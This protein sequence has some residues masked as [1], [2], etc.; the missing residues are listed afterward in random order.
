MKRSVKKTKEKMNTFKNTPFIC[1]FFSVLRKINKNHTA[2]LLVLLVF[3]G[4]I[5]FLFVA[6]IDAYAVYPGQVNEAIN[7]EGG[8]P[9]LWDSVKG[10]FTGPIHDAVE[11]A[12]VFIGMLLLK[13]LSLI[14]ILTGKLFDYT[15][16]FTVT[17]LTTNLEAIEGGINDAWTVLRDLA[18]MLF[19]FVLLYISITT[20]LQMGGMQ[21]KK[22]LKN[23]IIIAL[24]INFSMFFTH[25]V[26]D[27]TN[28]VAV[29]FHNAAKEVAKEGAIASGA[30]V[31][32]S[33]PPNIS[34]SFLHASAIT[35]IYDDD[36][37]QHLKRIAEGDIGGLLGMLAIG[38]VFVMGLSF[39]LLAGAFFLIVRLIMFILLIILSPLAF[40]AAILPQTSGLFKSW[41]RTLSNN[42][43]FAPIFMALLYASLKVL[44]AAESGGII[45]SDSSLANATQ[46]TVNPADTTT[47][48]DPNAAAVMFQTII[49]IGMLFASLIVAKSLSIQ[50]AN[51]VSAM[52]SKWG[53]AAAGGATIG[54]AAFGARRTI[55]S[56][57][58]RVR[59]S[60]KMRKWESSSNRF[61]A[62]MA[63]LGFG[64]ADKTAKSSFDV[65]TTG[66]TGNALGKAGGKGG[67]DAIRDKKIKKET[68]RMRRTAPSDRATGNAEAELERY[69]K[70]YD[71]AKESGDEYKMKTT[72]ESLR[73][74][75]KRVDEI[76]GVTDDQA[77]KRQTAARQKAEKELGWDK[78]NKSIL[79]PEVAQTME[80]EIGNKMDEIA[81][82]EGKTLNRKSS[83]KELRQRSYKERAEKNVFGN[84]QGDIRKA[85]E[86][87]LTKTSDEKQ[88]ED[89]ISVIREEIGK[90][91]S[92]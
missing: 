32:P 58:A 82:K 37:G 53:R 26:I 21:T 70:A 9:G 20:I 42:A 18:N 14:L 7:N 78:I 36:N 75:Q 13:L 68:E 57:A 6:P 15:V 43:L 49:A 30:T 8:Q 79:A 41:F 27:I 90:Q 31:D 45:S 12:I 69:K 10:L 34:H 2:S 22:L 39:I 80:R 56:G 92:S 47:S 38:G 67:Y 88:K 84:V 44:L 65:R 5:F 50:G 66:A 60:E 63:T 91:Q 1:S 52:G 28:S 25:I 35:S 3:F 33:N 51:K 40:V 86:K 59:D 54:A 17:N 24:L 71:E 16:D 61:K 87:E 83:A 74:A 73:K 64:A 77:Q 89:I 48:L 46:G 85:L 19:I 72:E 62:K 76:K 23:V 4:F 29:G 11:G 55:G 81:K